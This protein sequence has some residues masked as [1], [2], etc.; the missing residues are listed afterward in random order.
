M[1]LQNFSSTA[2]LN[3]GSGGYIY[4]NTTNKYAENYL[5]GGAKIVAEGGYGKNAGMGGSGGVIVFGKNF[6][7]GLFNVQINGGLGGTPARST[8]SPN[9]CSN[10]AAGTAYFWGLD[11]LL[12]DNE[13]HISDKYTQISATQRA[14]QDYPGEYIMAENLLIAEGAALNVKNLGVNSILF[15]TLQM[16]ENTKILFDLTSVDNF[17]LKYRNHFSVHESTILDFT[18]IKQSVQIQSIAAIGDT[19][20]NLVAL[21]QTTFTNSLLVNATNIVLNANITDPNASP[22]AF[23]KIQLYATDIYMQPRSS[24]TASKVFLFSNKTVNIG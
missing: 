8:Q 24:L 17:V 10:G 9:P 13:N 21:G 14:P 12:I 6:R 3:G 22:S 20:F 23:N 11:L 5:S 18:K 19:E 15:P 2:D 7:T 1:P 16:F 4:V